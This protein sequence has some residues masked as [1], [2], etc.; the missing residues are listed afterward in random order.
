MDQLHTLLSNTDATG[1]EE[2]DRAL[3][4][5]ELVNQVGSSTVDVEGCVCVCLRACV[6]AYIHEA[7][8]SSAYMCI[9]SLCT[10]LHSWIPALNLE[11]ILYNCD[12]TSSN[13][14]FYKDVRF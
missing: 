4:I 7:M 5:P 2:I 14:L 13:L 9:F 10:A 6:L 8:Y 1:L 3:G 12:R 11:N